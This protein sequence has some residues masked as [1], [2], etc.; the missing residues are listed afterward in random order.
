MIACGLDFGTSNSAIGIARG[1]GI[2]LAPLE[3]DKTLMPSAVFFDYEAHR[4]R[5]GSDAITAYVGQTEGRLMRALKTI[6]GSPLIDEKTS[7]GGRMVPLAEVVG[8]FVRHLKQKAEA[9]AGQ[10][11]TAVVHGRPVRFVDG[12]DEADAR[13][14]TV[15]ETIAR[16][17]GFRHIAFVPEPIAAAW[18]YEQTVQA[19][20]L[21]LIADIGGGTSDFSVVRI[22][23]QRRGRI[24]RT[25][26]ILATA[27]L[28]V[29]GTDFD[30]A[31]SLAAV[32]PLLGLGT[33]LV[34]KDLPMPN[35][36]YH[37]L[38]TWATINFAYTHKNEREVGALALEAAE[39]N[40]VGRLLAVIAKR[41]GH[42]VA[43]AVEDAKIALS[44]DSDA[45]VALDFVEQDLAAAAT[46]CGFQRAI[47][48]RTDRLY[49]TA[50]DCIAAAGLGGAAIDTIFL[51]GGSSRV[52]AVR[53]A[54]AEAAPAAHLASGSDLLSVASGLTR[55]AGRMA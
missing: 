52:P 51:T 47:H 39:P 53:A 17:A 43:F 12:D 33:R 16:Q 5:F 36:L 1:D 55:M 6:L 26:D 3:D 50:R 40:K 46:R 41:L 44:A 11:I 45:T 22:G 24:D 34:E 28:R 2:A 29:G 21:V 19:E 14:Q 48:S 25:E 13:A 8:L 42:R 54:I 27:G 23:P 30:S 38:A 10:E 32:M 20:E 7:L 4:A 37:E 18:H 15:L 35:A 49:R 31:L 9:F